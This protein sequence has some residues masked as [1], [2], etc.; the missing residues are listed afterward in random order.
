MRQPETGAIPALSMLALPSRT[1]ATVA[2]PRRI[3]LLPT[4]MA[5]AEAEEQDSQL[6]LMAAAAGV[7]EQAGGLLSR[8]G[9]IGQNFDL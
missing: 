9:Q 2:P 8:Y 7:T 3:R 1:P 6:A 4:M 5:D